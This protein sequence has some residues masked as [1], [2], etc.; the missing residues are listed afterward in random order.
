MDASPVTPPDTPRQR[1][2]A[3]RSPYTIL[4]WSLL[5]AGAVALAFLGYLNLTRRPAPPPVI[6]DVPD[7]ALT[8]HDGTIVGREQFAGE[9]WIADFIFT[10]CA[11]IC[12]RMT[13]EMRR[14]TEA[15][16]SS[17]TVRIA[18]FSVDPEH[19]TP[20]VLA[21]YARMHGADTYGGGKGWY[22]LTGEMETIHTLSREGFLLGV[23]S[24]P[25]AD[26]AIGDDPIL[27]SNRFVLVDRQNRIRGFYDPFDKAEIERLLQ[28]LE[29]VQRER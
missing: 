26:V 15:L 5:A 10:R 13:A 19:D 3:V 8:H 24:S 1:P 7:F 29:A 20:E 14:V 28:E 16:G 4:R 23:E 17:S 18:S 11:A 27:H 9:P 2:A 22:F 25:P 6:K 21:E 12:P